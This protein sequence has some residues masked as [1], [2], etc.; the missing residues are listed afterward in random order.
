MLELIADHL[1]VALELLV[2]PV[3]LEEAARDALT[4]VRRHRAVGRQPTVVA[5]FRIALQHRQQGQAGVVGEVD[6][7]RG[8]H[9]IALLLDAIDL[10]V[11]ILGHAHQAIGDALVVQRAGEVERS[12]LVIVAAVG[13][14]QLAAGFL[15][16]LLAGHRHQATRQA[17]AIEHR[18]RSLENVDA[19]D[20]VR[21]DLQSAVGAAV[22][23]QLLAVEVKVVHRAVGDAAHG[24]IVVA[25]GGAIGRAHQARRVAHRL[26]DG[27]RALILDLLAGDHRDG[28]RGLYQRHACLGRHAAMRR[29]VAFHRTQRIAQSEAFD[30]HRLQLDG[31]ALCRTAAQ[32]VVALAVA[33]GLQAAALQQCGKP[34]VDAVLAAQPVRFQALQQAAVH[35]QQHPGLAGEA[36]QCAGQRAGGDVVAAHR[37][38]RRRLGDGQAGGDAQGQAQ[39]RGADTQRQGTGT[40]GKEGQGGRAHGKSCSNDGFRPMPGENPERELRMRIFFIRVSVGSDACLLG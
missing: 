14:L 21:I 13:E 1:L 32:R 36:A 12:L 33:H 29:V 25:G 5:A 8:H 6:A 22:A 24:D 19:L 35:R 40:V 26:S 17:T 2:I 28:L 11:G 16:R 4:V 23:Q 15:L 34:V 39:Q 3:T 37:L 31:I 9:R 38:L 10:V 20:E 27:A 30:G 18:G 7:H